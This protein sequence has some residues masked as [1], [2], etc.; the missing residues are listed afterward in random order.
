MK[1]QLSKLLKSNEA[2][3]NL[4]L[5]GLALL[6]GT[7]GLERFAPNIYEQIEDVLGEAQ[8]GL[9][10]VVE[11]NDGD[12]ITVRANGR[13]ERVRLIGIDTPEKNHPEKPVQCFAEAASERLTQ[14]IGENDVGLAA[15]PTNSNRDRYDRLL[16]YVYLEDGR[17]LNREMVKEGYAFAYL[18]FPFSHATEFEELENS[19]R[20]SNRGLWRACEIDSSGGSLQT[21][22]A[23]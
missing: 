18:A 11:V 2:L 20:E 8:P 6:L 19:A 13:E 3:R 12:T 14:L 16:R 23:A 21:E 5:A 22:P 9:Y 1:K 7:I 15:D 4:V 10:E 17:L